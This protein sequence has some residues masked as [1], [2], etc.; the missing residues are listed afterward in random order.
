M[1][2][3]RTAIIYARVSTAKQAKE[4]L[5]IAS[6]IEVTMARAL[7][8]GAVVLEVFR[9]DGQSG[10]KATR[11][12]MLS[13]VEYCSANKVDY[14]LCWDSARFAREHL[15]DGDFRR[16]LKRH[17]TQVIE[18]ADFI[19]PKHKDAWFFIGL[20]ALVNEKKARDTAA[21]TMRSMIK[22]AKDGFFNGGRPPLGYKAEEAGKRRR[23]VIVE[24]EAAIV[25]RVFRLYI[26][27]KG[28]KAIATLL[29][30]EGVTKRG[31]PWSKGN[32]ALLLAN[33]RYIGT[34]VFNRR[35]RTDHA[36]H[37]ESEWVRAQSHAPII[38][39][40]TFERAQAMLASHAP[41]AECGSHR[42]QHVFTGLMRC[43]A[44]DSAMTTESATGRTQTYHYYNCSKFLKRGGC[45][46]RRMRAD[47]F[48]N[49]L[50]AE[51]VEQLFTEERIRAI[52]ANITEGAREWATH[53]EAERAR[54][55]AAMRK[56]ETAQTRLFDVLEKDEKVEASVIAPRL[57]QHRATLASLE[58]ELIELEAAPEVRPLKMDLGEAA[59][60]L[61][62]MVYNA[63]SPTQVR[64]FMAGFVREIRVDGQKVTV[65]FQ[66]EQIVNQPGLQLVHSSKSWLPE[67]FLLRTAGER[68]FEVWLPDSLRRVA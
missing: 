56:I 11:K 39:N 19:D 16:Q 52:M 42:S 33:Q 45:A 10:Q 46:T 68:R 7:E 37:P 29:N 62:G 58:R 9:D 51:L 53:R 22:N 36:D 23:L 66:P 30:A 28:C 21:D 4:E 67:R 26:D 54:I 12:S 13:A 1:D 57:K 18:V 20:R 2:R 50:V 63:K 40:E 35:N 24:E 3:R 6:Q 32:V 17:G 25:R 31:A 47:V 38:D 8:L 44:C 65:D 5:P 61:K 55:V 27:G 48:D 14:F 49:W 60:F 43:A 59:K 34:T 64:T 41:K 15:S